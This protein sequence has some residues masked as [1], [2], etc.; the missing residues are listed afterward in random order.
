MQDFFL[1]LGKESEGLYKEKGSKFIG[2]AFRVN[3]EEDIKLRLEELRK[4]YYDARHHVYAYRLGKKGEKSFSTD[5]R[6]PSNSAGPPVLAAIRSSDTTNVVVVVV[7]YF[8]GTKLGI[9]GLIEA[10]RTSAEYALEKAEKVEIIAKTTFV[11]QYPYEKTSDINRILHP[12]DTEIV[13]AEYTEICKQTI[14]IREE[15]F[16]P[17][18]A[19]LEEAGFEMVILEES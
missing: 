18:Q 2:I 4:K 8:G 11:L 13:Q 3:S 1:T 14:A 5:D 16:P 17:L 6:E 19:K 9:R 15:A 7:R 10:Y 12:F